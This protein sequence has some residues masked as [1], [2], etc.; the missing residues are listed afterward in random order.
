MAFVIN[1]DGTITTVEAD[2]DRYGNLRPKIPSSSSEDFYMP[3]TGVSNSGV[4]LFPFKET[5]DRLSCNDSHLFETG[6][7]RLFQRLIRLTNI[8]VTPI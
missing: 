1:P 8:S 3:L 4:S 5:L 7:Y 6:Y 2:Y